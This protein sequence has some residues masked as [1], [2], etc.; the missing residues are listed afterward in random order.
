MAAPRSASRRVAVPKE[1][2]RKIPSRIDDPRPRPAPASAEEIGGTVKIAEE[3][4]LDG[5]K[6]GRIGFWT[7]PTGENR[8]TRKTEAETLSNNNAIWV[9]SP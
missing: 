4:C 3:V 8:A 1:L 5:E 9:I 6:S 2:F 7:P